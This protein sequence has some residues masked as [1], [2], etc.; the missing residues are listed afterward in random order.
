MNTLDLINNKLTD[1]I[2]WIKFKKKINNSPD[3]DCNCKYMNLILSI[4]DKYD[5]K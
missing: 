4:Y 1:F 2:Y 5:H 3:L